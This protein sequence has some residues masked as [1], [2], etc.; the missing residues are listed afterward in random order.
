MDLDT[1]GQ[2]HAGIDSP[3][4]A[5]GR[6]L[7]LNIGVLV[8]PYRSSGKG[9]SAVTTGDV[10]HILEEKYGLFSAFYRTHQKSIA[11]GAASSMQSA[12]EALMLGQAIDPW[13]PWAQQIQREFRDFISSREAERVGM[14]GVPT[15][16]ALRG[17]NHRLAH[18]YRRG[19]ARRPS[20]R[21]T[22]LLMNSARAWV[23]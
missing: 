18:P 22:G 15:K 23:T 17:V 16:A 13:G 12:L 19:N 10:A 1:E 14:A 2:S 4:L 3:A 20:F 11:D 6:K 7:T 8:Q 5:S 21:D 9:V